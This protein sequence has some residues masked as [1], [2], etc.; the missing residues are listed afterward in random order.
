VNVAYPWLS[1]WSRLQWA[2]H[3]Q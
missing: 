2:Q 1:D 3:R